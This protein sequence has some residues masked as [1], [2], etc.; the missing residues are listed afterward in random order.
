MAPGIAACNVVMG[1]PFRGEP[2][3]WHSEVLLAVLFRT[4][5]RSL[6][7]AIN[8]SS[9]PLQGREEEFGYNVSI[10]MLCS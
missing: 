9:L 2:I 10:F 8:S 5:N 6:T 4:A 1:V 3:A 7:R